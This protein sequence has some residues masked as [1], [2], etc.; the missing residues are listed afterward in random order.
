MDKVH[1]SY[2]F[3]T[4]PSSLRKNSI[5]AKQKL[6]AN[7]FLEKSQSIINK[8]IIS[9]LID[10]LKTNSDD[11]RVLELLIKLNQ[12]LRFQGHHDL[13]VEHNVVELDTQVI[14]LQKR[15]RT[16][17]FF[18][19]VNNRMLEYGGSIELLEQ[20]D[21]LRYLIFYNCQ[22]NFFNL[23]L[24]SNI[25]EKLGNIDS[26]TKVQFKDNWAWCNNIEQVGIASVDRGLIETPEYSPFMM[27]GVTDGESGYGQSP[28]EFY[29]KGI[30]YAINDDSFPYNFFD[31]NGFMQ[32]IEKL[33]KKSYIDANIHGIGWSYL[34]GLELIMKKIA[35]IDDVKFPN[36]MN[37]SLQEL[38]NIKTA[39]AL[40]DLLNIRNIDRAKFL[41]TCLGESSLYIPVCPIGG[42]Q[43]YLKSSVNMMKILMLNNLNNVNPYIQVACY[44][45][46]DQD[47]NDI[48][49]Y[50]SNALYSYDDT[51]EIYNKFVDNFQHDLKL[52]FANYNKE[53]QKLAIL[54]SIL[55]FAASIQN[56]H[57]LVNHNNRI[58]YIIMLSLLKK[59]DL[60]PTS[61]IF[62][63]GIFE[64]DHIYRCWN[65][66]PIDYSN[67]IGIKP[68]DA[69]LEGMWWHLINVS[70]FGQFYGKQYIKKV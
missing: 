19:A 33:E 17:D 30:Y 53:W 60:P 52:A 48:E 59:Y 49:Y 58:A 68:H 51:I 15:M 43:N 13:L 63:N 41:E 70:G 57:F 62:I 50:F 45:N 22:S 38:K 54:K 64:Y 46:K 69:I 61:P 44:Q 7:L 3:I 24:K 31:F 67:E 34:D 26:K 12:K 9:E 18:K 16:I 39:K 56:S 40:D 1:T 47:N 37:I 25:K 20:L 66:E 32:L 8:R 65:L 10:N 11:S 23:H 55:N 35:T 29:T 14:E 36:N 6:F 21:I 2:N 28:I 42:G 27:D 5:S 4:P